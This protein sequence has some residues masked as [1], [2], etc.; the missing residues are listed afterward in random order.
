[1]EYIVTYYLDKELNQDYGLLTYNIFNND[2][3]NLSVFTNG[4][5]QINFKKLFY[6]SIGCEKIRDQFIDYFSCGKQVLKNALEIRVE[7]NDFDGKISKEQAEDLVKM[8]KTNGLDTLEEK[9]SISIGDINLTKEDIE[10]LKTFKEIRGARISFDNYYFSIYVFERLYEI[11]TEITKNTWNYDFSPLEK[12]LYVYDIIRTNFINNPRLN[13]KFEELLNVFT[14][15][16][17]LYSL[18]YNEVLKRLDIKS[19][20]VSGSFYR[21]EGRG[22]NVVRVIDDKYDIDGIYYVDI[23]IDSKARFDNSLANYPKEMIK[24]ALINSYSGFCKTKDFMVEEGGLRLDG[25]FGPLDV[26]SFELLN[27]VEKENG[28]RGIRAL[29]PFL[30]NLSLF[31]DN[32]I[33]VDMNIGINNKENIEELKDK[34]PRLAAFF[35][36]EIDDEDFLEMLLTVRKEEYLENKDLFQLNMETIKECL[37]KSKFRYEGMGIDFSEDQDYEQ[38][39]IDEAIA[40]SF[41]TYFEDSIARNNVE[42]R[43]KKIKL[44]LNRDINNPKKDDDK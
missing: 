31:L 5:E 40:E 6:T 14:E 28:I 39:D 22:I 18:L 34:I 16:S 38:E 23:S 21:T 24:D 35:G 32:E 37:F 44:S 12:M 20:D 4:K 25:L 8:I 42:D 1:M 11:I 13:E 43:I 17:F 10:I 9:I 7:L 41:D 27:E 15:P 29:I 36:K 2:I 33:L 19:M 30:N 3:I 26:N